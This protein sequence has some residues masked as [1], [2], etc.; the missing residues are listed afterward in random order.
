M[1]ILDIKCGQMTEDVQRLM[2]FQY[3]EMKL[4]N[5]LNDLVNSAINHD[6]R[7]SGIDL[8]YY[9]KE[10]RDNILF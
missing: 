7:G 4:N 1:E 6:V 3:Q 8:L 5:M 9:I 10:A 2:N